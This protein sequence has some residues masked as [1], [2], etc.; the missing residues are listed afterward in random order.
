[1]RNYYLYDSETLIA[2]DKQLHE[3]LKYFKIGRKVFFGTPEDTTAHDITD[4]CVKLL[5][6]NKQLNLMLELSDKIK[7]IMLGFDTTDSFQNENMFTANVHLLCFR[8]FI[9]EEL[10]RYE[11]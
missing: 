9:S 1:M 6:A 11:R 4:T 3:V 7:D 2:A 8:S 5:P 10:S